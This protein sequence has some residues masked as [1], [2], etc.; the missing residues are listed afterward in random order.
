MVSS[1]DLPSGKRIVRA[2]L[3]IYG[4]FTLA[5]SLIWGINT[6]FLLDAGLDIFQVMVVNG[7]FS[8]GLVFFEVPTGV[9]ADTIGRKASFL[10]G[11]VVLFVST[12]MYLVSAG[13]EWGMWGFCLASLLLGLGYTFQTGAVDAWLVD[14]LDHVGCETSKETVFAKGGMIFGIAMFAGTLAGGLL[15]QVDLTL[16]YVA[17]AGILV[18]AF[19]MAAVMMQEVGFSSTPLGSS[20]FAREARKIARDGVRYGWRDPVVRPLL[21]VS[22]LQGTFMMYFFYSSQPLALAVL[23]REDLIWVAG[24]MTALFGLASV[25]GNLAVGPVMKTHW[26]EKPAAILVWC[27]VVSAFLV[28]GIG[29]VGLLAPA[30]G[31]VFAC[32]LM[33][34]LFSTFGAVYGLLEPVRQAFINR[35]IPSRQRATV[36][37]LNSFFDEGGGM[38]GQPLFGWLARAVSIPAGYMAGSIVV[39]MTAPLYRRAGRASR[40]RMGSGDE[41]STT[42][43]VQAEE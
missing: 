8:A 28:A 40:A 11:I 30:A 37:S 27:T 31:S 15:G 22:G 18:V 6:L 13:H 10:I 5:T 34:L 42:L 29:A 43:S 23:G 35:H 25:A 1:E 38:M 20:T 7:V 12:L 2:Y 14:A 36:L 4:M 24:A 3:L 9:I 19:L 32:A 39:G 33:T 41:G 26:G 21:L 17:R 16:P